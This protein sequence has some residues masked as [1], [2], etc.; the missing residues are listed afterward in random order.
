MVKQY[1]ETPEESPAQ[2]VAVAVGMGALGSIPLVGGMVA[3]GLSAVIAAKQRERDEEFWAWTAARVRALEERLA[4][5][6]DPTDDEF[7]VAAQKVIRASRET[8]DQEKRRLLAE[9]LAESGSWSD[10]PYDRR[11]RYLDVVVR[12]T[13]WHMRVL[14]YFQDPSGWFHRRGLE[15]ELYRLSGSM[16]SIVQV[17][18]DYVVPADLPFELIVSDLER[19]RLVDVPLHTL[20]TGSGTVDAR[21]TGD[22]AGLLGFL[23]GAPAASWPTS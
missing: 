8:A 19:E 10:I 2:S 9:V 14:S 4:G 5:V 3:G 18:T 12:M 15:H 21:T 13:P 11:E 22:G 7:F 23:N 6:F 1:P 17:A 20:M 16:T